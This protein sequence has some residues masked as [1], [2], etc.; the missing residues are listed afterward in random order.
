MIAARL[1]HRPQ[2]HRCIRDFIRIYESIAVRV[3]RGDDRRRRTAHSPAWTALHPVRRALL[4]STARAAGRAILGWSII[5]GDDGERGQ[6]ERQ[7]DCGKLFEFHA[8]PVRCAGSAVLPP[9]QPWKSAIS[10]SIDARNVKLLCAP[11][12][13]IVKEL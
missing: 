6:A 13:K 9:W 1:E 2:R 8:V 7:R 5:L 3:Q 12:G 10:P 11:T 4:R